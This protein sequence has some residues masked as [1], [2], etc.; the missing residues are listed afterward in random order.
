MLAHTAFPAIHRQVKHVNFR[1]F[2]VNDGVMMR[3][4]EFGIV[5][6]A[7]LLLAAAF[8]R[9]LSA[10]ALLRKALF[11]FCVGFL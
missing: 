9:P 4:R 11:F 1:R 7:A 8:F 3:L 10:R 6:A 2:A 5:L